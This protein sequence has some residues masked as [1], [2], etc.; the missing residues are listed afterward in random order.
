MI[1]QNE[2]SRLALQTGPFGPIGPMGQ[3]T[4]S[5]CPHCLRPLDG[6][7]RC[8]KCCDRLCG[9]GRLT[10]SAFIEL[11]RLCAIRHLEES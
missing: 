10:G 6:K 3:G 4:P 2:A 1:L 5:R 9:C 7:K 8:W 11:C